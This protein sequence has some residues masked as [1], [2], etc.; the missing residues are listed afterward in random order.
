MSERPSNPIPGL[1]YHTG[2][3]ERGVKHLE[4]FGVDYY[5]S[6]TPEATEKADAMPEMTKVATTEPFTIYRLPETELVE[7]AAF[8]P[9]VYE[10]PEHGLIDSLTGSDTVTGSDGEELPSFFD[11][12]L[13]WYE[14]VDN[15]DRLVVA[16]GPEDWPRI[17]SLDERP[18]TPITAPDDAVR[19][20]SVENHRISFTTS[21]VGLPHLIKVSYFPNWTAEG[22]EGPWR[23][24]P[25]LM[26]VVPTTEDVVLEFRDTWAETG[27]KIATALALA[28]L[29]G[30]GVWTVRRRD[31]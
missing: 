18:T 4:L 27:G 10:V 28:G 26:V 29:I 6:F 8:Q 24:T 22:A 13:E 2:D 1:T 9:S 31:A 16:D 20:V 15:L 30:V 23:A 5:V 3:M 11:M 19:D 17:E 25:S 14:D 21:A 12:A 7:V